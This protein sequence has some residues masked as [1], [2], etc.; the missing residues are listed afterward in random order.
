MCTLDF[1]VIIKSY[2]YKNANLIIAVC[3]VI[4]EAVF[5]K[6]ICHYLTFKILT[7]AFVI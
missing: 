3:V 2:D 6:R 5:Y 7:G 1:E 4:N